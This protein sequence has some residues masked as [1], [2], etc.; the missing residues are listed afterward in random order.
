MSLPPLVDPVSKAPRLR[1]MFRFMG[2][3]EAALARRLMPTLADAT[4]PWPELNLDSPHQPSESAYTFLGFD[5]LR[6]Y[7]RFVCQLQDHEPMRPPSAVEMLISPPLRE[8]YRQFCQDFHFLE[9]APSR[10]VLR[11]QRGVE[12]LLGWELDGELRA[13]FR[14]RVTPWLR[15]LRRRRTLKPYF[16]PQPGPGPEL[17]PSSP[18]QPKAETLARLCRASRVVYLG[19]VKEL[20]ER[21]GELWWEFPHACVSRLIPGFWAGFEA[22]HRDFWPHAEEEEERLA[23][24]LEQLFKA[25]R[26]ES[27]NPSL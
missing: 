4:R 9:P 26:T 3:L 22:F 13:T 5:A 17:D 16:L 12:R 10:A 14:G 24:E 20:Q 11:L 7:L 8:A 18:I 6:Y 15:F 27:S 25:K 2:K 23:H 21:K 1:P 19:Y